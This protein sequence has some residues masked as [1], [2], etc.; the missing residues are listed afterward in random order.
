MEQ[1]FRHKSSGAGFEAQYD[2]VSPQLLARVRQN[3]SARGIDLDG[4]WRASVQSMPGFRPAERVA[5]DRNSRPV[6]LLLLFDQCFAAVDTLRWVAADLCETEPRTTTLAQLRALIAVTSRLREELASVRLLAIEGLAM[7]AMQISRS[8]SEDVDLALVMLIRRRLA[9]RFVSCATPEDSAD[10]WRRHVAG[11]RAFRTVA[12]A[13]YRHGLDHS[14]DSDYMRWRKDVRVFLGSVVHT[15]PLGFNQ[16]SGRQC[17]PFNSAAQEC[18]D[19]VITRLQELCV[20]SHILDVD[21]YKDLRQ[22]RDGEGLAQ[23]RRHFA[24]AAGEIMVDQ[25]R[26]LLEN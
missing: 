24:L 8:V 6:D 25:R 11:G 22:M 13:L 23:H 26:W 16:A 10:F 3:W 17:G 5:A 2:G 20:Y 18:L 12:Q 21:L 15:S 9:E 19:F 14:D 1:L 4:I 7:P